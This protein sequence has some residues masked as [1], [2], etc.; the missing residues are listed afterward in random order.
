MILLG[1]TAMTGFID[2]APTQFLPDVGAGC[3]EDG[4]QWLDEQYTLDV[5]PDARRLRLDPRTVRLSREPEP[6]RGRGG[7]AVDEPRAAR[8][9]RSKDGAPPRRSGHADESAA[10]VSARVGRQS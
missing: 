5:A 7:D 10:A 8:P 6:A 4:R 9:P 3:P 2:W 1:A